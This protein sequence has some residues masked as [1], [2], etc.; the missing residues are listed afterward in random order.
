MEDA[1]ECMLMKKIYFDPYLE[2]FDERQ[3]TVEDLLAQAEENNK[4]ANEILEE[5]EAILAETK[6]EAQKILDQYHS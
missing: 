1:G 3:K 6:K 4:K 5:V 2:A